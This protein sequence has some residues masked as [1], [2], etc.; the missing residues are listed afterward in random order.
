VKGVSL[1][2]ATPRRRRKRR[3][4]GWRAGGAVHPG[5]GLAGGAAPPLVEN[6]TSPSHTDL[7]DNTT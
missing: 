7:L 5:T 1:A 4:A 2:K 3:G 6:A